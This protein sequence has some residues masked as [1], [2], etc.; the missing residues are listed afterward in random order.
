MNEDL[1][2][3]FGKGKSGGVGGGGWDRYNSSGDRVGKCGDAKEG[4][5]YSACLSKE[6]A[7]KLGKAGRAAFVKRKRA[8]QKKGGDAKKGGEQTKGQNPIKVKTGVNEAQGKTL[9]VYDFDDT[10][11]KTNATVIVKKADGSEYELDSHGFATHK[12]APGESYDFTN[13]DKIIS[14]S[15]PILRNIKQ[16]QKSLKNPNIK[17]TILTARRVAYPIMQHLRDMYNINAYVIGVGSA[18]PELK[19]DWI[20]KQV[21]KGYVN[22]KFMD[23]SVKNLKA[24]QTRL[25]N[26]PINLTLINAITGSETISENFVNKMMPKKIQEALPADLKKKVGKILFGDN[27]ATNVNDIQLSKIKK[28]QGLPARDTPNEPNTAWERRLMQ[29]L[30]NW[31]DTPSD[32]LAADFIKSRKDLTAL[33]KEYPDLIQ[34]PIGKKAY[35][36][37]RVKT[38]SILKTLRNATD[39]KV[40]NLEGESVIKFTNFPYSPLRKAQSWSMDVS[41]ALEFANHWTIH[42][43]IVYETIVDDTNW[44][45]NPKLIAIMF[46]YTQ[47]EKE[48]IRVAG[49]GTFTAYI[50]TETLLSKKIMHLIPIAKPF[51]AEALRTYNKQNPQQQYSKWPDAD[52]TVA[53]HYDP[54][55]KNQDKT[56]YFAYIKANQEFLENIK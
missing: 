33:G 36:G 46:G 41:T 7:R 20:E 50:F 11:V 22:I 30:E 9:H 49:A 8:A 1:R 13:L 19:A 45:F 6:K 15:T 43:P 2:A 31:I 42:T 26:K 18:N 34:P 28:L 12:L 16:I 37:S 44:I 47:S 24:V 29:D 27:H 40:I 54:S 4:D 14:G 35:R 17:T 25:A 48:T 3:W 39:A 38:K 32:K 23:D 53:W 56:L 52:D 5:P 51:F 10:L 21:E 55:K